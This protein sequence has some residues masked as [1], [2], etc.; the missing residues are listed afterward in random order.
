M[1]LLPDNCGPSRPERSAAWQAAQLVWYAARPALACAA[2][3]GPTGCWAPPCL[4]TMIK[5]QAAITVPKVAR[6]F[7]VISCYCLF[8]G[9]LHHTMTGRQCRRHEL[10]YLAVRV[11]E[12]LDLFTG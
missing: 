3:Y 1:K 8:V 4:T 7:N 6:V 9:R 11:L 12:I 2:V 5:L 10:P